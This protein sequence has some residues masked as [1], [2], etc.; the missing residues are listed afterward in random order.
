MP[1]VNIPRLCRNCRNGS[2]KNKQTEEDS[3]KKIQQ[4]KI[5]GGKKIQSLFPCCKLFTLDMRKIM[6][7]I[8]LIVAA[9]VCACLL[10]AGIASA[11]QNI[12]HSSAGYSPNLAELKPATKA[13]LEEKA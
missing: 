9:L 13:T 1:I 4:I 10:T 3:R 6:K 5:F 2:W 7:K 8:T 12:G 11:D